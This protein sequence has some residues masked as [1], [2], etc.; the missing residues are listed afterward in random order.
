MMSLGIFVEEIIRIAILATPRAPAASQ[1]HLSLVHL[2]YIK[3]FATMQATAIRLVSVPDET[4][5]SKNRDSS[6]LGPKSVTVCLPTADG[7]V[8]DP[9]VGWPSSDRWV[10]AT[11]ARPFFCRRVHAAFVAPKRRLPKL[12]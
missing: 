1:L 8:R 7:C 5:N 12:P 11:V 4:P 2:T 10:D 6:R 9:T 3:L